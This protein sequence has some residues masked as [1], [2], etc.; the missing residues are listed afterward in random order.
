MIP[1]EEPVVNEKQRCNAAAT[2]R[3]EIGGESVAVSRQ[4]SPPY[5]N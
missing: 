5:L 2:K 3:S 1:T 4:Y